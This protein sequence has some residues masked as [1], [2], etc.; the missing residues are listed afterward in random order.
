M[1]VSAQSQ[2]LLAVVDSDQV[3]VSDLSNAG[4]LRAA[5]IAHQLSACRMGV[6]FH[7]LNSTLED[8]ALTAAYPINNVGDD[9]RSTM[10]WAENRGTRWS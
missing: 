5:L 7:G 2:S 3:E 9:G 10:W 4:A 6:K 8:H 1:G